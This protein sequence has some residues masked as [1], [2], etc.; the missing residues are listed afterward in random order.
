MAEHK[1]GT[2]EDVSPHGGDDRRLSKRGIRCEKVL[3]DIPAMVHW[4]R[5]NGYR[6][7]SR[8]LSAYGATAMCMHEMPIGGSA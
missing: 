7:N 4:C 6:V 1:V 3:I 2:Y 5:N 8:G